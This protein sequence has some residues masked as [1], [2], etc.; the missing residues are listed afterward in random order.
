ML[1]AESSKTFP[2]NFACSRSFCARLR[3]LFI[4][5]PDDAYVTSSAL[6]VHACTWGRSS[7]PFSARPLRFFHARSYYT[8]E[9]HRQTNKPPFVPLFR[10]RMERERPPPL[11]LRIE[12]AS[13]LLPS[14]VKHVA[15]VRWRVEGEMVRFQLHLPP[16]FFF[17]GFFHTCYCVLYAHAPACA[18]RGGL[19]Q[20]AA[21]HGESESRGHM[22]RDSQR[23]GGSG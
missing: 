2:Q 23:A 1:R 22:G 21:V 15:R 14:L 4:I 12:R 5:H 11:Q 6:R 20:H 13:N 16:P 3:S 17:L 8:A 7:F 19:R 9:E 10:V 18:A